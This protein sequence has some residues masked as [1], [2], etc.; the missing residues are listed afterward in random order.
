MDPSATKSRANTDKA[1]TF[2]PDLEPVRK[3]LVAHIDKAGVLVAKRI[4]MSEKKGS[5]AVVRVSRTT[6]PH[7]KAGV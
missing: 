1:Y 7:S 3:G 6:K 5:R 2:E 4:L